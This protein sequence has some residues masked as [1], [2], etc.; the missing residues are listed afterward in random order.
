MKKGVEKEKKPGG[1]GDLRLST[2]MS[3]LIGV[4]SAIV[5]VASGS[6]L[7][8]ISKNKPRR[9]RRSSCQYLEYCGR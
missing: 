3:I 4:C 9:G 5:L 2:K 7:I 1:F 6:A 8:S